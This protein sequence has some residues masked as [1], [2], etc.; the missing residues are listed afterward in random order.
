MPNDIDRCELA[1]LSD[2]LTVNGTHSESMLGNR[3]YFPDHRHSTPQVESKP[4]PLR[5]AYASLT[6]ARQGLFTA[7]P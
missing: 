2:Y 6:K 7:Q 4:L 5:A 3:P 1:I